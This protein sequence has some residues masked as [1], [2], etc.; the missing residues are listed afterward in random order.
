MTVVRLAEGDAGGWSCEAV[1]ERER[2]LRSKRERECEAIHFNIINFHN[3]S[4]F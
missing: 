1:R 4:S 2:E 3:F